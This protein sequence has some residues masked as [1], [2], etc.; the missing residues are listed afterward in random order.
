[1]ISERAYRSLG[2]AD[3]GRA[4]RDGQSLGFNSAKLRISGAVVGPRLVKLKKPSAVMAGSTMSL[5]VSAG[6]FPR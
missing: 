3:E 1:V 6:P 2:V 5:S 4:M